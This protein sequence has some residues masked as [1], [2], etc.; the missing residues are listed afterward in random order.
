MDELE[1][2]LDDEIKR[3]KETHNGVEFNALKLNTI[4]NL[5]QAVQFGKLVEVLNEISSG[6]E[7]I[8]QA[9]EEKE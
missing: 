4:A 1:D 9:I 2:L 7:S 6:L 5:A 3:F 8:A